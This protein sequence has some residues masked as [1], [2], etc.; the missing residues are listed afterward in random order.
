MDSLGFIINLAGNWHLYV[1]CDQ[2]LMQGRGGQNL[3][4]LQQYQQKDGYYV[5][6][7]KRME[8]TD[9]EHQLCLSW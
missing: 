1:V 3:A 4:V 7:L 6:V 8:T 9:K 5:C 2:F